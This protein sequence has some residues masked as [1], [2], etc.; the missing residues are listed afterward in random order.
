VEALHAEE[1]AAAAARKERTRQYAQ[2]LD[3]Q[4]REQ[5][6]R[7]VHADVAMSPREA[8]LNAKL[9]GVARTAK[10]VLGVK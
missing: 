3:A 10:Q 8:A 6:E 4:L 7:F 5:E 1:A 9:L 2:S